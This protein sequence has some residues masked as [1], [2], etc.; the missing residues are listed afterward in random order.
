MAHCHTFM[1][2]VTSPSQLELEL[3]LEACGDAAQ[4]RPGLP[5]GP[6][7][8][9]GGSAAA[10]PPRAPVWTTCGGFGPPVTVRVAGL[11]AGLSGSGCLRRPVTASADS[12]SRTMA[13]GSTGM[14]RPDICPQTLSSGPAYYSVTTLSS[15]ATCSEAGPGPGWAGAL[16]CAP[17]HVLIITALALSLETRRTV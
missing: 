11:S 6:T 10:W 13:I 7:G 4:A 15:A 5:G 17:R 1:A 14:V 9:R 2:Q 8:S 3:E 16:A 12:E